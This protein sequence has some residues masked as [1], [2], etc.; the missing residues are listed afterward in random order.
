MMQEACAALQLSRAMVFR[1][2]AK[3]RE[4]AGL[5]LCFSIHEDASV[6]VKGCGRSRGCSLLGKSAGSI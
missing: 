5:G 6:E 2:P 3:Y 4:T 1:L